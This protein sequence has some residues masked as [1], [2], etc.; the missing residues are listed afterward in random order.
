MPW[1]RGLCRRRQSPLNAIWEGSG[2]VIAL[3][4]LRALSREPESLKAVQAEFQSAMG[5]NGLYDRHC[6]KL[7]DFMEPGSLHEGTARAF[8]QEMALALQGAALA[9]C[10]PDFVFDG[11]CQQRLAPGGRGFVY[12]DVAEAVDFA[13]IIER[14]MPA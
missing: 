1:R 7:A 2:N 9:Q 5:R 14:A 10:A 4:I 6:E 11:F 13:S 8:A 3:D 12:G